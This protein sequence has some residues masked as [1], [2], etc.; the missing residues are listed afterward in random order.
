[1]AL[2]NEC[3]AAEGSKEHFIATTLFT[4]RAER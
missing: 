1:M 4:K 3:G 2:V